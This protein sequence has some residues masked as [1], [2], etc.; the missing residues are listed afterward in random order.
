[1]ITFD[2][3]SHTYYDDGEKVKYN[4]TSL[5]DLF[6]KPFPAELIAGKVAKR[7]GTTTEAVLDMWGL[8]RDLATE[9]GNSVHKSVELFLKY[10][11]YPK[12][13]CLREIVQK[14]QED[15][16][17]HEKFHSEVMVYDP[18]LSVCG[19]IDMIEIEAPKVISIWDTKTNGDLL[20]ES[21]YKLTG[22]FKD[23]KATNINK[24]RIQLSIYKDLLER[25][26]N[27]VSRIGIWHP[28]EGLIELEPL[29]IEPIWKEIT[30]L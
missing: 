13:E 30:S 6:V 15:F 25:R 21:K 29:N 18:E 17:G 1:M 14:F 19:T 10:G 24:Y 11:E 26:G 9:Y 5:V 28:V 8:K 27:T 22:P 20:E 16:K 12:H 3:P 23:L 4:V 2:E 7:D